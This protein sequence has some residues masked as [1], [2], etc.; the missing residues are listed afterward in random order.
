MEPNF[1][2]PYEGP[3]F[4][5][6]GPHPL[7]GGDLTPTGTEELKS[8]ASM[9]VTKEIVNQTSVIIENIVCSDTTPNSGFFH[10][11]LQNTVYKSLKI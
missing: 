11:H 2:P 5:K 4:K 3:P 6:E 1:F 7:K 8:T 9:F 10:S